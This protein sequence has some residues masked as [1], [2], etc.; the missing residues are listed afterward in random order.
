LEGEIATQEIEM[1]N[2]T[3][4]NN[5]A[6]GPD[7]FTGEFYKTF[8]TLLMPDIKQVL[9]LVMRNPTLTLNPLNGSYIFMIPKSENTMKPTDYKPISV[10]HGIQK[11]FS[12]ILAER[13]QLHLSLL[14]QPTQTGFVKGRNFLKGLYMLK[15]LYQQ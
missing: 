8:K 13:I 7:G 15:K 2:C 3:W 14:I 12:K 4:P 9:N 5:K 11:V 10:I 1:A 6:L